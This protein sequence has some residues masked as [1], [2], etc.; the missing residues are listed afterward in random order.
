MFG[1]ASSSSQ[2]GPL[3]EV[4]PWCLTCGHTQTTHTHTQRPGSHSHV[5]GPHQDLKHC[6][7]HDI[8]SDNRIKRS[9]LETKH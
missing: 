8:N 6:S 1:P 7:E 4:S 9:G 3:C 5:C 2:S